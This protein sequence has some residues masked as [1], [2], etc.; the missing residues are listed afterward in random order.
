[1]CVVGNSMGREGCFK[2]ISDRWCA[3]CIG[4]LKIVGMVRC[5]RV[6][7]TGSVV[8]VVVV[9]LGATL[10]GAVTS[11]MSRSSTGITNDTDA[12][13]IV[14]APLVV[15]V[16]VMALKGGARWRRSRVVSI[17]RVSVGILSPLSG[18]AV[19]SA[20]S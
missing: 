20:M 16:V 9:A 7:R 14:A 11:I 10:S 18:S 17:V 13:A 2:C 6:V 19:L 12:W 4:R 3:W 8:P 5:S 15:A 1:M